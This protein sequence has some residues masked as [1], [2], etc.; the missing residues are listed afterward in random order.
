MCLNET[1]SKFCKGKNLYDAFYIQNV[2]KQ[3]ALSPQLFNFASEYSIGKLQEN[4]EGFE[5]SGTYWFMVYADEVHISDETTGA[6]LGARREVGLEINTEKT[7]CM[8]MSHQQN[9][10]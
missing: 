2:L 5:L 1:Y 6:L 10:G 7:M 8:V 9:V 3:D 4:E